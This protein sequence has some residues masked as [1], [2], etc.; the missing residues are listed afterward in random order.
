MELIEPQTR[1]GFRV[2]RSDFTVP[3][4]VGQWDS[5]KKRKVTICNLFINHQLSIMEISRVLDETY[6]RVVG[7]LIEREAIEDRR[8]MPRTSNGPSKDPNLTPWLKR[9]SCRP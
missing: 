5:Q 6:E 1:D 8:C 7:V 4:E 2:V 3:V 9:F